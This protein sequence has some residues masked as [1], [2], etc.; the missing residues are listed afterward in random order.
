[1]TAVLRACKG[2]KEMRANGRGL[3]RFQSGT[4]DQREVSR[5]FELLVRADRSDRSSWMMII[6]LRSSRLMTR[7]M[8]SRTIWTMMTKQTSLKGM[9]LHWKV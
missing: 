8:I 3:V 5:W 1:M 4:V 9:T 2:K 7:K 6:Q